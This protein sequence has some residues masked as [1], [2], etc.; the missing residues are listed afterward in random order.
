[1]VTTIEG[2]DADGL[3]PKPIATEILTK[4]AE[5]SVVQRLAGTMP[6]PLEGAAVA[7]QTGHIEAGVVGEGELKPVGGTSYSSKTIKPIKV[8]AISIHSKE[9]RR[10]N[11]LGVLENI[12]A[13]LSG[14]ITRSFDLAVMYGRNAKTGGLISDVE[15][16][17]QTTNRVILGTTAI[18]DGGIA[19]DLL[20]GYD[21]VVNGDQVNDDFTGFAADRRLRSR[22]VG[23]VDNQGRPIFQQSVDLK[24]PVDNVLGLPAAYGKAV[25]GRV[26]ASPA[27]NVLAF[28][29][30]WGGIKYGFAEQMTLSVS[31]QATI[32]DGGDTY[33]LW[34]Q[35]LEAYL[36]EAIFGWVITDTDSFVAYQSAA[37]TPAV[38]AAT[39]SGAAAGATVTVEGSGF[40]GVSGAGGVKFGSSNATSYTVVDDSTI[41][42]VVPAGSAGTANITVTNAAGTSNSFGYTRG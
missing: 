18:T 29:G 9:L 20:N 24:N 1:M 10:R 4:A 41:A 39:P 19:K 21:L 27:S 25:S 30:D 31:D 36:V 34:Q 12:K 35:N 23:A 37:V 16:I 22:L 15:Y 7:V 17:N 28:G 3:V 14:A 2:L 42:A 13:D 32:V 33:H 38:T 5:A 40:T 26:G 8:A 11:P 6:V